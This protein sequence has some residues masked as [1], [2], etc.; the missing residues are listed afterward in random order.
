MHGPVFDCL[1]NKVM[2]PVWSFAGVPRGE[3][4]VRQETAGPGQLFFVWMTGAFGLGLP[5]VWI[6]DLFWKF[7]DRP[8]VDLARWLDVWCVEQNI[9]DTE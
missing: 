4:G 7:V 5:S 9:V 8:C 6:A 3:D 1:A 2:D